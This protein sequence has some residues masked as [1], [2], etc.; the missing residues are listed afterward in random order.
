MSR[1]GKKPITI[2]ANVQVKIE[3]DVI[4]ITGPKG[5][6]KQAL[7][8]G[9]LVKQKNGNLIV[10]L[11]EG[12]NDKAK[13]GLIRALL[14]NNVKGVTDGFEKQ[15]EIRGVGYKANVEG[16]VLKLD[17]G[18]SHEIKMDIFEG[19]NV[20]VEK[21][22][23]KISGFDKQ[24]VGEFAA[25]VRKNRPPEPYKGKGIRYVDEK[26]RKKEGKKAAT[27]K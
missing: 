16:K 17:V 14:A 19:L 2:P 24:L 5:E 9:V 3:G 4:I 23:I 22:I 25:Q 26:V 6:L 13:W 8:A 1:I 11:R 20:S 10:F 7:P 15:L 27:A 21:S 18:F 12:C